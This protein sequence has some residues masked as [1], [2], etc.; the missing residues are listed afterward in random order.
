VGA[1]A[2]ALSNKQDWGVSRNNLEPPTWGNVHVA[3]KN[4]TRLCRCWPNVTEDKLTGL[5]GWS[6][7]PAQ[8]G[9]MKQFR[10]WSINVAQERESADSA[11]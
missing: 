4:Y 2:F 11:G 8:G 10:R 5:L 1:F 9:R 6:Q 3:W 7:Q